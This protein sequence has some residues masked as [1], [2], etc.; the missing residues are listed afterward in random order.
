MADRR[1]AP[2]NRLACAARCEFR[3]PVRSIRKSP[4][5]AIQ[6]QVDRIATPG[7]NHL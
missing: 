6:T 4:F 3:I 5:T 1:H 7:D 2:A